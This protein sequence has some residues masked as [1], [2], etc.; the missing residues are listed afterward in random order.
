MRK[1]LIAF[2]LPLLL[3]LAQQGAL[4]HELGHG[5]VRMQAA[6]ASEAPP[7]A[8]KHQPVD[9]LC[10]TCLAYAGVAAFA[11]SSAPALALADMRQ[12]VPDGTLIATRAI[13]AP[14]PRSRGPPPAH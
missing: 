12:G 14:A 8:A 5:L 11:H 3:L 10:Q 2:L 6:D 1:G 13:A 7:G 9:K 4:L